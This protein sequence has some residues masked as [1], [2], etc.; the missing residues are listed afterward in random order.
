MSHVPIYCPI[1]FPRID[2]DEMRT[3]DYAVMAQ[4]FATQ[5]ELGPLAD[6]AVYQS[7]LQ[8]LL[9]KSGMEALTE[10]P[11]KL[12]FRE[13]ST[14]LSMDLVI[15]NAAIYELKTVGGLLS[16]HESQLLG[17]LYLTNATHG[18]LVNFR[19][20]SVE[21]RFVNSTMSTTE[22]QQFEFADSKYSGDKCLAELICDL[23]ADW[24]TGLNASLYRRAIL[25][26]YCG[27]ETN[28]QQLPMTSSGQRI[29]NQRFHLLDSVTAIG[30]TT[31][32]EPTRENHFA[33]RKLLA[34]SPLNHFHWLNVTHHKVTLTT[35]SKD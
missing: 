28:E 22:R 2:E 23:I 31:F 3:I 15:D 4:V 35:I 21:S 29:G 27:V 6:E 26:C 32:R 16:A 1:E 9:E 11:I 14:S 33:F 24:G 19:T 13:F 17:Y 20:A 25:Y 34:A 7:R 30:V 12:S 8:Q 18:K 10:V 5:N